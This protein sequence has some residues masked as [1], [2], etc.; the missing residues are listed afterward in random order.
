MKVAEVRAK[1]RDELKE[2]LVV[3]KKE[4]FNLRVQKSTG[5]LEKTSRIREVRREVARINTVL[6]EQASANQQQKKENKKEDKK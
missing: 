1:S 3:L 6:A 4:A 2:Q 5:E